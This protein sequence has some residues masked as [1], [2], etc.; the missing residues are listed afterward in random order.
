MEN[1]ENE[2]VVFFE[3]EDTGVGMTEERI[4]YFFLDLEVK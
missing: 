1:E 4:K 2:N 3:V